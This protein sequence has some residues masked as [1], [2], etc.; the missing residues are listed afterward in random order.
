MKKVWIIILFFC[1]ITSSITFADQDSHRAVALKFLEVT[2]TQKM[3]DQMKD[4]YQ[5][6]ITQYMSAVD[7]PPEAAEDYEAMKQDIVKLGDS[8]WSWEEMKDVYI[9]I[10]IKVYSEDEIKELVA[11]YESPLG[12]KVIAKSPE[13][14]KE[15]VQK[16]QELFQNKMPEIQ[17][18]MNKRVEELQAKYKK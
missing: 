14:M 16:S 8:F 2:E 6:L 4:S 1:F 9:D 18:V 12:Q 15:S 3:F 13:L 5:Q 11:F 17:Q 7:L 10:I